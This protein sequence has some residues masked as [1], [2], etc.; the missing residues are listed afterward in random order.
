MNNNKIKA[1]ARKALIVA[2]NSYYSWPLEQ[3]EK[4]RATMNEAAQNKVESILLNSL[5]DFK[6]TPENAGEIWSELPLSKLD[7]LNWAKLLVTGIGDDY[8]LLN[9]SMAENVS[10]LD[11]NSLYDYDYDDHLFQ[12]Q[13]NKK[14]FKS[15]VARDYYAFRFSRWVR[16]II[17]D[18]FYYA[19]LYSLAG[20]LTDEMEDKSRD[21][22]EKLI[23]HEYIEG[24]ENGKQ[25]KGGFRWDM[26][27]DAAGKEKQ[28]D[29]LKS[30][31]YRYT[32]QRW[33]EL[34]KEFTRASPAVFI[35][36]INRKGELNRNYIFNNEA[37]LKQIRWKHFLADC[38]TLT[39]ELSHVT[40]R[41]EL[42][43]A[44]AE[45]FLKKEHEDIMKNFDP[46]V[47]K[48]KKK[49]KIVLAPG[50][51]DDLVRN[52]INNDPAE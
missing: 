15:Y 12:E 27:V 48:L 40:E 24:K 3:Q 51:L 19:N 8:I 4:F 50:A 43:V 14:E 23:P 41:A 22:I 46:K 2:D 39:T 20:Y 9:E 18:Q 33:L 26:Q 34:S 28:L 17:N 31:W 36:D 47:V 29:E 5:L 45:D 10:L 35:E 37:A 21:L 1:A 16:L 13:A 44:R 6:S 38:K 32:Q 42:E 11:F 49:M 30:R 7:N 52:D 25:V